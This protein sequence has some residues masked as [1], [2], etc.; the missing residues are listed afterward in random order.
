MYLFLYDNF[1]EKNVFMLSGYI[2]P[3]TY[4]YFGDVVLFMIHV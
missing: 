2:F 1:L 4:D 3:W